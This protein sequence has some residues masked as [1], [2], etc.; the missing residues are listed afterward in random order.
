MR[1]I[2]LL[3]PAKNFECGKA[4]IDHGADAVYIGAVRY[5]ARAA[6]GNSIDDIS[7]LCEY[8]HR[9]QAKVYV[10]VNTLLRPEEH[11]EVRQLLKQLAEAHVDA[12]LVQDMAVRQMVLEWR[13]KGVPMPALHA[14]TQ[15]DNRDAAKVRR[16][17]EM[18]FSRVVLAR[19]LSLDEIRDICQQVPQI[20]LEAFVHGAL[21][22][23]YSGACYASEYCFQRSANRGECAQFCRL[24]FDLQDADG[25]S[26]GQRYW[27]SLKDMCRIDDLEA[28]IDAGVMSLKIE[29]RLKDADYVKNVVA[30]YSER[31]N[32]II[33][34]RHEEFCRS[35][36]GRVKYTFTPDLRKTF[37]RGYTD[38]FLHQR[39]PDMA[40]F[41]SPK[42]IGEYVGKV[43]EIRGA[44]F[45]VAGTAQFANGDGLCFFDEQRQLTGFRINR[46]ENNRLFPYKMPKGLQPG[47]P[48]YR[49][50]D[51]AFTSLLSH[52]TAVRT[53]PVKMSFSATDQGFALDVAVENID[54][55]ARAEI[56]FAHQLAQKPQYDNIVRQ[57]TKLGGTVFECTD[58]H[59]ADDA[60]VCFIPSSFLADLRRTAIDRLSLNLLSESSDTGSTD[61]FVSSV[62]IDTPSL[63]EVEG[64]K[65]L[66]QCRHC[67]RYAL[68]YCV[69]RGGKRPSWH[70]PLTLVMSDGRKFTLQFD[71]QHCQMNV[72]AQ[73]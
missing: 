30:A 20:E 25:R 34:R 53:I 24:K 42:A 16:L 54:C 4:A 59:V 43:K 6:A 55:N 17:A 73:V 13:E 7:A 37:N 21:C 66:M 3:A 63:P 12:I 31:L 39:T 23:C 71:C 62:S 70:E 64:R 45:N 68:G 65:L 22:V 8:A 18:G 11:D 36:L 26:L 47:T 56:V 1:T 49:N 46:V 61:S 60:S 67:I 2:E 14:S 44:S 15:T 57:L 41:D 51:Q 19:E 33:S 48:L 28:M 38:Y 58:I 52:D 40:S 69:R 35:S 5:G 10:T 32:E 29:G 9:F 27:L 50:A 72:Y